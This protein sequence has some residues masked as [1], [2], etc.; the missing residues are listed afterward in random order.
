MNME[1]GESKLK[2]QHIEYDAFSVIVCAFSER[3]ARLGGKVITWRRRWSGG[4]GEVLSN[5]TCS[6]EVTGQKENMMI[7]K[8]DL[9]RIVS[10]H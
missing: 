6:N 8:L 2:E 3:T 9:R 10:R 1:K 7:Q 4:I 5:V